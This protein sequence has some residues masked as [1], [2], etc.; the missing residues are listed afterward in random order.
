MIS[1]LHLLFNSYHNQKFYDVDTIK[2]PILQM[3]EQRHKNYKQLLLKEYIQHPGQ[4]KVFN[5]QR[6]QKKMKN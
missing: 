1:I 2:I 5:K 4:E 3:R 6:T